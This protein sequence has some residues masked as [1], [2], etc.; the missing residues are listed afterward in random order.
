MAKKITVIPATINPITRL[1]EHSVQKRRVCG[2]ARVSTDSDE[3]FTSY[4]AQV[5]YYTNY[6]KSKPE[7]KFINVYTDEG[8]SAT[9]TNKREG[10]K[11]MIR[12]A[13]DGKIDLI[14]TKSVSRFARNTVDSLTTIRELKAK[15]VEVYFEK[16][17][18]WTLDSKGELLLTIMS[19]L[20]QE[21][22][23]SISEN[24]TW[25]KRK[26][27]ADGKVTLGYK[28]FLGYDKGEDGTLVVN[29]KQA[30]IVKRIYR[31][32][33]KG[34][35]PC[36]IAKGLTNDGIP[37][38]AGKL[39]KWQSSVIISI[40]SNEKYKGAA[41]IQKKFTVD[42]LTK[43][44]KVNEGEIPQY[45]I[46]HD[47]EPII[48]PDEWEKVQKEL[49]RRKSTGRSYSGNSIFS[50]KVICGDCGSFYGSKVWNSTN[51]K[52][53]R[54]IWQCNNKFKNE[55]K[56]HTPHL[57]EEDIKTA[58]VKAF[59]ILFTNID[60]IIKNCNMIADKLTDTTEI[61]AEILKLNQ[62]IA[63]VEEMTRRCIKENATTKLDQDDYNR[64]F[65]E[66][67]NKLEKI[68]EKISKLN[69]DRILKKQKGETFRDFIKAFKSINGALLEFDDDVWNAT[70]ENVT[71][72][73]D[74]KFV[75]LFYNGTAI[76]V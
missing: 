71:I 55:E 2:Y 40:L 50:S 31:E 4:E 16:E 64:V 53:K 24:V 32:F 22:S 36:T 66:Y 72:Q 23:R 44:M 42:F 54:T 27:A 26:C 1:P 33:M 12:D 18:I 46:E 65:N 60:E 7:W 57:N 62:E 56:C 8:I 69:T 63:V 48:P 73:A 17:N 19:S 45:Y 25:G 38:P 49:V 14:V 20:A 29:Q 74:G 34:K 39:T 70:V 9:N 37:T 35:T 67:E 15:G 6:I 68:K 59:N 13:I 52:Y 51:E 61:E 76:E 43:K 30:V 3:Q 28:R 41:L 21:E 5:D 11:Q 10:F 58:F 47:H 75:F